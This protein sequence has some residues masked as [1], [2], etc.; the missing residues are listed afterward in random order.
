[1][2][3][4]ESIQSTHPSGQESMAAF[5]GQCELAVVIEQMLD[6]FYS[7]VMEREGSSAEKLR[8]I[9]IQLDALHSRLPTFLVWRKGSKKVAASGT[10]E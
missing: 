4:I 6:D 10:R 1:M 7:P 9:G 2:D 3:D 8:R 5:I